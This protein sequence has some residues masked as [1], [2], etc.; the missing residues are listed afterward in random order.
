MAHPHVG[1][2]RSSGPAQARR[3][4]DYLGV[5]RFSRRALVLVWTTSRA[6]TIGLALGALIAGLLPGAI[7]WVGKLLVDA[8]VAA[9]QHGGS[10]DDVLRWVLVEAGLVVAMAAVQRTLGI[11]RSLLRAQLGNRVNV[12]I[13]EKALQ[14]ELTHF[15]DAELYDRMTRARREASSRPLSLVVSTFD[16]VQATI[17]LVSYAA[18]LAVFS[19]IAVAV[20]IAAGL[21]SFIAE[22]KFAGDAFRLFRWRT[23][24]T[25]EQIYLE[26]VLAR[27]DH[28]KEVKLF[29]LGRRFLDRYKA[30]FDK[31]YAEDRKL[32]LR[33]GLWGLGLGVVGTAA[34]Y[35]AY[36]WI[37]LAAVDGELTLGAMT[38]YVVV[39]K[40]GQGALTQLLG[41]IGGM[42]EDNLYLSSLY[43]LLDEPVAAAGGT[44]DHG[45]D[46]GDGLRFEDVSFTYPGGE[47]PALSHVSVHVPPGSKLAIVGDNGSGKTTLVKL[48]ARLYEPTEGRIT[49]EGLDLRQWDPQALRRKIGVIFQDFVR[50]Q[51]KVGENVGAGDDRAYDDR[52]R[53]REASDKGL[54]TPFIEPMSKGFDTQLGKWF[55]DGRELSGGQWQKI[56]L[57]RAFMRKEASIL[58]LDEPTSAIDADAEAKIFER[59]REL[60]ADQ[61]AIVISHRFSTVRMADTILVLDGG[62]VVERGSHDELVALGGR[63]AT[64]FALQA[65][66]YR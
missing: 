4:R 35:G 43:E 64:L 29:G 28:V 12:M 50:Y 52:D 54:A 53:W 17:S 13:L 51:L 27:E 23:P 42:Y 2:P 57:S 22:A 60:T 34:F 36:V 48:L 24:E 16:A 30:I 66:G 31:L 1:S 9:T 61:I 47:Q 41:D 8:V 18:L 6:L 26:T 7:A 20:L 39:F 65:A 49:L 10:R 25:R 44:A 37:A 59:F 15:E 45:P 38:M 21:P 58:V 14:L 32:T 46:P 55:K 19:P 40:Q 11:L 63:Y 3:L 62:H 5:F 56:A 33:R